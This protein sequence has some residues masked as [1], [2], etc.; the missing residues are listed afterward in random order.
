[1]SVGIFLSPLPYPTFGLRIDPTLAFSTEAIRQ[2]GFVTWVN[3]SCLFYYIPFYFAVYGSFA[4]FRP[5]CV[6]FS[7][8]F[9][10]EP[11]VREDD[12]V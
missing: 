12:V 9:G 1:M 6:A 5:R 8:S 10:T 4:H 2:H 3:P 11:L 7:L